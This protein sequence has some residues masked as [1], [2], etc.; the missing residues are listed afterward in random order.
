MAFEPASLAVLVL[1]VLC[2]SHTKAAHRA[3]NKPCAQWRLSNGWWDTEEEHSPEYLAHE[4]AQVPF[5]ST[6]LCTKKVPP[7]LTDQ[8]WDLPRLPPPAA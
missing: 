6:P 3:L 1:S 2:S 4:P 8:G 5:P 7:A